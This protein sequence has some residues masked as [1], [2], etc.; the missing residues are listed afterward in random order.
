MRFMTFVS[1][2]VN[3]CPCRQ[4]FILRFECLP[5][6]IE[7]GKFQARTVNHHGA[8]RLIVRWKVWP[9]RLGRHRSKL[10]QL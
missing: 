4:R 10:T 7:H 6:E 2:S 8:V 9:A 5:I 1:S 3:F